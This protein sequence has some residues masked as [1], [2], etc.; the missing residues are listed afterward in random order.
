MLLDNKGVS[1]YAHVAINE[2]NLQTP[3]QV[4]HFVLLDWI[5]VV[6]VSISIII[7]LEHVD[8]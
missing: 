1:M 2:Y 8:I 6:I 5:V 7:W 3:L 4:H